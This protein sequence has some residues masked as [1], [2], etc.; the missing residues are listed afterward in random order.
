M[1]GTFESR[2]K[3]E[4]HCSQDFWAVRE[5]SSPP[6]PLEDEGSPVGGIAETVLVHEG[7]AGLAQRGSRAQTFDPQ[8]AVERRHERGRRPVVDPPQARHYPRCS[9][10]EEA[11]GK[12][13]EPFAADLLAESRLAAG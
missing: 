12:P 5:L 4:R 9:R 10:V 8:A 7:E 1:S 11:A 3:V 13:Q 2:V 6:V